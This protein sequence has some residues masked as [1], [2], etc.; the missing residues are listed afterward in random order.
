MKIIEMKRKSISY[1]ILF[2]TNR[3]PTIRLSKKLKFKRLVVNLFYGEK[4]I[5]P[6]SDKIPICFATFDTTI[7]WSLR[8]GFH[9]LCDWTKT[10]N[11]ENKLINT[12]AK[13]RILFSYHR[14]DNLKRKLCTRQSSRSFLRCVDINRPSNRGKSK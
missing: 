6:E 12:I 8:F 3:W 7:N 14:V 1:F 4:K 10:A 9:E 5:S 2:H 11:R 13:P